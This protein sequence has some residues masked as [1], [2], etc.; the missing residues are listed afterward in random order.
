MIQ[1]KLLISGTDCTG[2]AATWL[3][4]SESLLWVDIDNEIGRAHV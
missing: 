4:D 1:S 2:E 3:K